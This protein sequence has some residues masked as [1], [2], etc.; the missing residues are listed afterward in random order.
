MQRGS[1]RQSVGSTGLDDAW[2]VLDFS[3]RS[4]VIDS[5]ALVRFDGVSFGHS[6]RHVWKG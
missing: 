1:S 6:S 5:V 3:D 4:V 2:Q